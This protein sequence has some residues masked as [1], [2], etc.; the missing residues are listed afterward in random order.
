M[1]WATT[2]FAVSPATLSG[3]YD[4]FK[5]TSLALQEEYASANLTVTISIQSVPVA[6]PASNPNSLGFEPTSQPERTLLNIGLAFQFEDL[7]AAEGLRGAMKIFVAEI[8]QIAQRDGVN[9]THLYMN[10]AGDWQDVLAGYGGDSVRNMV[11]VSLKYDEIGMFQT[12]VRGG[13]KLYR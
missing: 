1:D 4:L 3:V 13:F 5:S 8:D 12:Q 6:A 7:R 9:D 10:Y 11:Q 2:T